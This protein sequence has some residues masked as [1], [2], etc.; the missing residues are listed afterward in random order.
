MA[1]ITAS[2]G[3]VP[4]QSAIPGYL[5]RWAL[6]WIL[7]GVL[8]FL[9]LY[10]LAML[11]LASFQGAQGG[12]LT[13]ANYARLF[14]QASTWQLIWTTVWMAVLRSSFATAIGIFLAW[15]V[16]RTDTPWRGGISFLVWIGFFAPP[17]PILIAWVLIAGRVGILNS[18]LQQLPFVS[19][20]IFEVYS[21]SG[22]IWV[23]SLSLGALV[24]ILIEPAFRAMDSSLEESARM[25]GASRLTALT[26]I[27][28]PAM[29]PAILGAM[30]YAFLLAI[31]SFEPEIIFGTPA[32]STSCRP[33]SIPW[34]RSFR[35]ICRAPRH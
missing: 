3:A 25:C 5:R 14:S 10:P 30:F 32:A 18:L 6:A 9:V 11:F 27:T 31:E 22:I 12:G 1:T 29:G 8:V 15:V 28:I 17:L 13:F 24:F 4:R 7:V 19:G 2:V 21:Y 23:S 26:R 20:P 35:R 33:G 16:T 34:P